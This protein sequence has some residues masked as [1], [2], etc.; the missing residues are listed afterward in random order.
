MREKLI[1]ERKKHE[2]T[3]DCKEAKETEK[4]FSHIRYRQ[5]VT[6]IGGKVI[7]SIKANGE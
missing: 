4:V 5:T 6:H 1:R 2:I 3:E 7:I